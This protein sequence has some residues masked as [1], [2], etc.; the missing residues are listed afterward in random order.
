MFSCTQTSAGCA[1]GAA[2]LERL[3]DERGNVEI[4]RAAAVG[5]LLHLH[6]ALARRAPR[7]VGLGLLPQ[8]PLEVRRRVPELP[9]DGAAR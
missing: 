1:F 4:A 8:Q 9:L 7:P 6:D 5:D 3:E 2:R